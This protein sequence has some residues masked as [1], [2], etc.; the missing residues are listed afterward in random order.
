MPYSG[1]TA[2]TSVA[3]PPV[4]IARAMGGTL[5]TTSTGGG[6]GGLWFYASTNS[7]TDWFSTANFFTDAYYLG[8]RTGDVMIVTGA[9][10]SSAY[11][12]VGL[13]GAVTTAGAALSSSGGFLSST[14]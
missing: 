1:A 2:A 10:G 12:A 8:M 5:N 6:G 4:Q 13:V 3:N 9:T 7:S 14:R 11:L